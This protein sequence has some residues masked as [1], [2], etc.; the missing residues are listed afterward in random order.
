MILLPVLIG[1][2]IIVITICCY[3][4]SIDNF[5]A[6]VIDYNYLNYPLIITIFIPMVIIAI[7]LIIMAIIGIAI[8][9]T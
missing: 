4:S 8:M 7:I 3:R 1:G 5:T 2:N 9:I 6:I